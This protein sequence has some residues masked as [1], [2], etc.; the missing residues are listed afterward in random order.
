VIAAF[1]ALLATASAAAAGPGADAAARLRTAER[2]L[3]AVESTGCPDGADPERAVRDAESGR[4]PPTAA[5]SLDAA[6]E[7]LR[8]YFACRA[9]AVAGPAPCAVLARTPARVAFSTDKSAL[10]RPDTLEFLCASDLQDMRMARATI[11]GDGAAFAAACRAHDEAGHRDF[12]RGRVDEACAVLAGGGAD[13]KGACRRL[14]PLFSN[15]AP[16]SFCEGELRQFAGDEAY[17]RS[18]E[19]QPVARELCLGYAAWRRARGGDASACADSP[20]CRV[21]AGDGA[22]ACA[23]LGRRALAGVCAAHYAPAALSAAEADL[24]A[25]ERLLSDGA[26]DGAPDPARARGDDETAEGCARARLKLARLRKAAAGRK[27]S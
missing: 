9:Y 6:R 12:A 17:C 25:A 16:A 13:P 8:L 19:G 22:G 2:A 3:A 24:D 26:R 27:R 7:D 5:R 21:L 23:P 15:P 14:A 11:A 20:T 18:I 4:L 1:A 10:R